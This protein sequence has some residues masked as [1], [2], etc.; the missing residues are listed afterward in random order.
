MGH[1]SYED[2][3]KGV[4]KGFWLLLIVTLI[5]VFVSLAGKGYI[6]GL[7]FLED[8]K[9]GV[10]AV[11]LII[12]VLSLYKAYFIV[13]E[14]MHMGMEVPGLRMTVLMPMLL[15]VWAL[16]AFFSEG[17]YWND[18]RQTII[19]KNNIQLEDH[20]NKPPKKEDTK[21]IN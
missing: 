8:Y 1:L 17:Q 14:F 18:S 3:K 2:A 12:A 10:F 21:K 11:G 20:Q 9:M 16:I 5:E 15:L 13:Y 4:F 19:D 6:P 7:E